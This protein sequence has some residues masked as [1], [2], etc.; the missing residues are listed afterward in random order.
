M[1]E[2]NYATVELKTNVRKYQLFEGP[3][4]IQMQRLL[5]GRDP[6]TRRRIDVP[7]LPISVKV[8]GMERLGRINSPDDTFYLRNNYVD[9]SAAVIPN[10]E[11][12]E[13][14]LVNEHPLIYTL[15]PKT[16]LVGS[17]L[18]VTVEQYEE[19]KGRELTREQ[20]N[21]LRN[22][23]YALPN[24]RRQIWEEDFFEGDVELTNDYIADVEETTGRKFERDVMGLYL[25]L[26]KGLRSWCVGW[27]SLRSDAG[28][29][30]N[31]GNASG[32]LVGVAAEPQLVAQK[33][34]ISL[35]ELIRD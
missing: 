31:L 11:G 8:L 35:D 20:A 4:Y 24:L 1:T 25:P 28:G 21:A 22:D 3:N 27:L 2:P 34:G 32:R 10:P 30:L 29:N 7:R 33:M 18:P 26:N 9:T 12:N 13:V 5:T 14:K 23:I 16:K 15:T 17:N 19:I 6:N